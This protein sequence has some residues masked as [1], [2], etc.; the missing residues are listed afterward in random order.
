M[1]M[2][3]NAKVLLSLGCSAK[4]MADEGYRAADLLQEGVTP[5]QMRVIGFSASV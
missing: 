1:S 5:G 3:V 4:L 2:G